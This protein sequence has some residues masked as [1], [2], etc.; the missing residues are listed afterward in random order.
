[1][2]IVLYLIALGFLFVSCAGNQEK[3]TSDEP[4]IL[5]EE[6]SSI[7]VSDTSFIVSDDAIS[8]TDIPEEASSEMFDEDLETREEFVPKLKAQQGKDKFTNTVEY[9]YKRGLV[10]FEINNY[11]EGVQEFDTA[12]SMD[13]DRT[14][15]Y[16]N[17]GKGLMELKR[18]NEACKDFEQAVNLDS[19]DTSTYIY[20]ATA[21]YQLGD[22]QAAIETNTEL[23]ILAPRKAKGYYNRGIAYGLL[24]EF[25]KAI[26]DFNQAI[27]IDS[28]YAEAFFNRGLAYYFKGDQKSACEDW[29]LAKFYGN[30]KAIGAIDNYC[31]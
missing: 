12:I 3:Q 5:T 8:E 26:A 27:A 15:S 13:P 17:R 6:T 16:I 18:Y 30:Q 4:A 10:L 20:L 2:R 14:N 28:E 1:M 11:V 9:H 23:I 25:D 24:K 21:Q 31:E 29:K 19:R 7:S 22:Y